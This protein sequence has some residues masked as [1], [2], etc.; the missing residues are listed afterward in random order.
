MSIPKEA[1]ITNKK[2]HKE[3]LTPHRLTVAI[4]INEYFKLREA[5]KF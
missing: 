5:G 2:S 1:T 4:L 3:I